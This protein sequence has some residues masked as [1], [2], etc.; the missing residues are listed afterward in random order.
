MAIWRTR[1]PAI[2]VQTFPLEGPRILRVEASTLLFPKSTSFFS[3][4][5]LFLRK[6]LDLRCSPSDLSLDL[7]KKLQ[8][9]Q[10]GLDGKFKVLTNVD[11]G[12]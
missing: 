1:T 4:I 10:I 2:Q 12:L 3:P 11:P 8:E 6:G 7:Q 9:A 5:I